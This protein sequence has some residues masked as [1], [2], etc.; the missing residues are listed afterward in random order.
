MEELLNN[1]KAVLADT[2]AFYLKLHFFHWNVEGPNFPQYH[3]LF[4]DLYEEVH[5]S[6][7]NIAE[8]IRALNGYAPGSFSRYTA[9][10]SIE[11]QVS[12]I[13]A[14]EMIKAA[15]VDN[16]KVIAS[17]TMAY[18]SAEAA[19]EIGVSNF[20]QDRIDTHKKHGWMLRA[21]SKTSMPSLASIS[22]TT[23]GLDPIGKEDEDVNNDGKKDKTDDYIKNRRDSISKAIKG[24]RK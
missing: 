24:L 21:T 10:T 4:G 5:G 3:E 7:D 9:L 2:F 23:E 1:M 8:H 14:E 18:K 16:L 15:M 11:D 6:V 22:V 17:L 13:N 12:M 20:L 19:N